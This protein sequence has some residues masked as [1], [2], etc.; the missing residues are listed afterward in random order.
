ML[1][2]PLVALVALH[3]ST[4]AVGLLA[5]CG[6]F[7]LLIVGFFAGAWVD[8]LRYRNVMVAC[9]LLRAALI[10]SIPLAWWAQ[11]LTMAHMYAVALLVGVLTVFFDVADNSF[12]PHLV[13]RDRLVEGNAV[14]Q[15]IAS[16]AQTAGPGLAGGVAAAASAPFALVAGAVGYLWSALWI[17]SIGFR[18]I[19][20]RRDPGARLLA[21]IREG[22]RFLLGHRPLR[23]V[24]T[25]SATLNFCGSISSVALIAFMARDLA[26]PPTTIGALL[27][28][29]GVGGLVGG[30]L[31]AQATRRL[32]QGRTAWV[33]A[34]LVGLP[35][36]LMPTVEADWR[37][38]VLGAALFTTAL[39]GLVYNV[40]VLSFRQSTTPPELL[41]RVNASARVLIVGMMPVG[42]LVGG[43]LSDLLGRRSALWIAG[44]GAALSFLWIYL[45]PVRQ[46]HEY[47]PVVA[48][49]T[50]EGPPPP[51]AHTGP[52][53]AMAAAPLR[54][55]G[56]HRQPPPAS[57]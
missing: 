35:V 24:I 2:L 12:A 55:P 42:S 29:T 5:A 50:G 18:Q 10:A 15:T 32:G 25:C 11:G 20:G 54:S 22:L 45:S 51:R 57:S 46:L 33:S 9:D 36:L 47:A 4:L 28:C 48:D 7:P 52:A 19:Q 31:V 13:R 56:R 14:L 49:N 16:V 39:G 3:A 30:V 41:G 23:A 8:R 6:R 1:A 17:T 34:S 44:A 21:E 26:L 27:T 37:L 40:T 43:A 38:V 53:L